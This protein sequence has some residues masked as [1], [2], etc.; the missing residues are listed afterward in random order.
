MNLHH[1]QQQHQQIYHVHY[2]QSI[3]DINKPLKYIKQ[4]PSHSRERNNSYT[5]NEIRLFIN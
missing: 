2:T 1:I 5:Q 3:I 4:S